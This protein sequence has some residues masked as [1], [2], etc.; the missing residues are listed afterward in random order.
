MQQIRLSKTKK[1]ITNTTCGRLG[2][3]AETS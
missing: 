2:L 1:N 3:Y